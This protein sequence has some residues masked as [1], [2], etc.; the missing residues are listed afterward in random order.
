MLYLA[1]TYLGI[2]LSENYFS[3]TTHTLQAEK[4][5]KA[6]ERQL[7]KL[8]KDL[9]EL[10]RDLEGYSEARLNEKPT[11]KSWSVFQVMHHLVLVEGYAMQYVEK[12]LSFNPEL[13]KANALT[14]M[15]EATMTTLLKSPLRRK[16]PDAVGT[17]TLP[18]HSTFWE[19]AKKWKNQ[20]EDL[21]KYL[22]DL[23]EDYYKKEIYKH[24][25]AGRISIGGMLKF[26]Q[27]HFNRHKK[28]IYRNLD[29]IDAV[30]VN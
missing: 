17:V 18:E 16:A 11:P 25:F 21:K 3:L 22:A 19:I 10:L 7:D 12:K 15:R 30:K 4:M 8:H 5:T 13:K 20:R 1:G 29:L 9:I 23:P 2:D 14:S 28:Q 6:V 26:F 24:P 27:Q